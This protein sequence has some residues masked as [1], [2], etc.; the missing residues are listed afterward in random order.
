[1]VFTPKASEYLCGKALYLNP[2]YKMRITV[3]MIKE[4]D[5]KIQ[6]IKVKGVGREKEMGHSDEQHQLQ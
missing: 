3:K 1:V 4:T 2:N 5:G 6:N